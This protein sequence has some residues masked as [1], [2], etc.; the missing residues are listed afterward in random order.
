MSCP[1]TINYKKEGSRMEKRLMEIATGKSP[2][3]IFSF[4]YMQFGVGRLIERVEEVCRTLKLNMY[5]W[6]PKVSDFSLLV[7]SKYPLSKKKINSLC[8]SDIT[9]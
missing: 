8:I 2:H 1:R 5:P 4:S 6:F 3:E 9:G 7:V